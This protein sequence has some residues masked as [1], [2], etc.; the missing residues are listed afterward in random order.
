LTT[1]ASAN[2]TTEWPSDIADLVKV[3]AMKRIC[4]NPM[5]WNGV[6]ERLME[7]SKRHP[8]TPAIPPTPLI[9]AGWAYSNDDDKMRRWEETTAWANANG[10]PEA[11][12]NIPDSDFYFVD[13]DA[14]AAARPSVLVSCWDTVVPEESGT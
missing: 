4:P 6:F 9:L 8:C 2:F 7:H 14:G 1:V 5:P 3:L 13:R 12:S 10:C 11:V